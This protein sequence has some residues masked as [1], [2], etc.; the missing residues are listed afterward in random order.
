MYTYWTRRPIAKAVQVNSMGA[1]QHWLDSLSESDK[2]V[3]GTSSTNFIASSP[4]ATTWR[5]DYDYD[6]GTGAGGA[7]HIGGSF[8]DYAIHPAGA[9]TLMALTEADFV[10]QYEP[11]VGV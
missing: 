9:A 2:S 10:A 7:V 5:V 1:L 8:G 11:T 4:T 6:D 3:A